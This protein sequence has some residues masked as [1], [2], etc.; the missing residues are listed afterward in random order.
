M[1]VEHNKGA[2]DAGGT[3]TSIHRKTYT[4]PIPL[5]RPPPRSGELCVV[6]AETKLSMPGSAVE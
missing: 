4:T 1:F 5:P 2:G 6:G 3:K